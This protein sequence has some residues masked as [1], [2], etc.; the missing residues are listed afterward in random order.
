MS[1]VAPVV[2]AA[3]LVLNVGL[4]AL[5]AVGAARPHP[6]SD[7]SAPAPARSAPASGP[8]IDSTV[9][10][11][12]TSGDLPAMVAR[13]REAGFPRNVVRAITSAR[14]NEQFSARQKALDPNADSRPFWKTGLDPALLAAQRQLSRE[15]MKMLRELL[16]PDA[17]PDDPMSRARD[18]R[19]FGHLPAQKA[20]E[21]RRIVREFNDLRSDVFMSYGG[22]ITITPADRDKLTAIEKQMKGELMKLMTPEEYEMY[23]LRA[24]NTA[25]SLRYQLAAFDATE[26]EF[27]SVYQLQRTFD[28]RFS[29]FYGG[30][31]SQ[32][33]MRQR[34]DAQRQLNEQIKASLGPVRAEFYERATN[35]E[36]R[37]TS[38]LVARLELPA[39]TTDR[40]WAIRDDIQKRANVVRQDQA[41]T[42][43]QRNEKFVALQKEAL[44]KVAPLFGSARGSEA[45]QQYGG[46]W[47]QNLV[48]RPTPGAP[49]RR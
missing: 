28:D 21:A 22:P 14:L 39:E 13:L 23:D 5:L 20:D 45:Y 3:S 26:A 34:S 46:Q 40:A 41:L 38:Q 2:L 24:G 27:R 18:S 19:Q 7:L 42:P 16:G 11:T 33:E 36:Y 10:P 9:W 48:P 30:M 29:Q 25:N 6:T 1:K 35:Y 8:V 37:T 49:V 32:E 43:A 31:P 15:Q 12:L 17:E 44:E 47:I 4:A